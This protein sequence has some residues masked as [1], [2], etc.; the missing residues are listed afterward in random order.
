MAVIGNMLREACAF[1]IRR[2]FNN[3]ELYST[4]FSQFV[5]TLVVNGD[6]AI[7]FFIEGTRSRT[8]KCLAPKYGF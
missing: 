3:D 2:S 4:I 1:F 5:E 6:A 8:G 7:E